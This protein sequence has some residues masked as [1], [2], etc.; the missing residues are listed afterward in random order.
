M[1]Y[2][3]LGPLHV[4]E[5]ALGA[6]YFGT[7]TPKETAETL[8]DTYVEAGGNFIDTSNNYAFWVEGGHAGDSEAMLG[9]WLAVSPYR[10]RMVV[11][12]KVGARP[13][14]AG[15][16]LEDAE[17]LS[18]PT[19]N[20][21]VDES[22]SRLRRDH[23]DL[24]YAHIDDRTTPLEETLA[25]FDDV[26]RSGKVR[27]I[28]C[29]NYA[30]WRLDRARQ[31]SLQHGYPFY[32]CAQLRHSYYQPRWMAQFGYRSLMGERGGWGIEEGVTTDHLDYFHA[33]RDCRLV[34]YSPLL[35]G[36]YANSDRLAPQYRTPEN[37]NRR[38]TLASVAEKAN[39]TV[40]QLVLTW[41]LHG[42][43]PAIPIVAASNQH[44]LLENLESC[45]IGLS[46][47]FLNQVDQAW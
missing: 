6:M 38:Q 11:A 26:V 42:S 18:R 25:G 37:E 14:T 15:G 5:M 21:A 3:E 41:M 30:A 35:Q 32:V 1:R 34:A 27:A 39:V 44:Q 40:N 29:S 28:G 46:A 47:E 19:I 17:G 9:E 24:L 7:K 22:L 45:E 8:I 4:S 13:R 36:G 2:L 10:N 20:R 31:I 12:T 23:I 16:A 33:N 43:R